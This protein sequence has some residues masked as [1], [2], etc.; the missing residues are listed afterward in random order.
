MVK[1]WEVIKIIID[2]FVKESE[3]EE[4]PWKDLEL[5]M[6]DWVL[7]LTAVVLFWFPVNTSTQSRM[8]SSRSFHGSSSG[9]GSTSVR[10]KL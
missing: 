10:N 9:S 7:V 1:D 3:P 2:D 4:D 5:P 6:R 8:G